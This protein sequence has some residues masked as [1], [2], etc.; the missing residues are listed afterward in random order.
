MNSD[1][2]VAVHA[3]VYLNHKGEL[4]SSEMLAENICTNAARVRKVMAPL[5]RAGFV[6]TRE[7]NVG[8]Y[9]FEGNPAD[10]SLR[11]VADALG[12]RFVHATWHS[13]D[14]DMNCLVA[15]GMADIMDDILD[16]LDATCRERLEHTTIADIDGRI[17]ANTTP[18][19]LV[20]STA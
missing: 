14:S 2:I 10:V 20:G 3:L 15:S 19:S 12:I 18:S 4:I 16:D 13:G 5:K 1:F 6:S 17:F 7:G 8:G 9:R 11:A